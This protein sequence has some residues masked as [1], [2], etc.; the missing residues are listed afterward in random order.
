ML[1]ILL[2]S[3]HNTELKRFVGKDDY[4]KSYVKMVVT[5]DSRVHSPLDKPTRFLI[6]NHTW[7]ALRI[8]KDEKVYRFSTSDIYHLS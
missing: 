7:Y 8:I 5:F 3:I 2:K 1:L 6:S 4:F